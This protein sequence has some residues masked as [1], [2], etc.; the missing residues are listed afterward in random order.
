MKKLFALIS[1]VILTAANSYSQ[2]EPDYEFQFDFFV[3][4]LGFNDSSIVRSYFESDS[5]FNVNMWEI[6]EPSF[7]KAIAKY[8]YSDVKVSETMGSQ[9]KEL[10]VQYDWTDTD[11][12]G[13]PMSGTSTIYVYFKE[14]PNGLKLIET[15][16]PEGTDAP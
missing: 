9:F 6:F 11:L 16:R 12:E 10:I 1:F 3:T 14:T 2:D 15:F 5:A 8:S 13:K 7:V 4:S